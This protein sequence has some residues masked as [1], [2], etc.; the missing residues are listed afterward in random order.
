[1]TPTRQAWIAFLLSSALIVGTLLPMIGYGSLL[2]H[3]PVFVMFGCDSARS[4]GDCLRILLTPLVPPV[5]TLVVL[6]GC[7]IAI[8]RTWY[9]GSVAAAAVACAASWL[10]ILWGFG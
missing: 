1:M 10:L 3:F 6:V 9:V 4:A 5:L 8:A 7:P 2:I